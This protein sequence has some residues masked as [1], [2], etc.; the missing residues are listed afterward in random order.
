MSENKRFYW[1]KLKD[2]FFGQRAIKK[3]RKIAGGD[4][5]T[6]I[7]LKLQLLSLKKEGILYFEGVED[8]FVEEMALAIDEDEENVRFTIMFLQKYGLIEE[9][10]NDE[11]LLPETAKNIGS[12]T[13]VAARVRKHREAKN[14]LPCNS[15]VTIGNT[16]KE[17]E[18]RDREKRKEIEKENKAAPFSGYT[19]NQELI[20]ALNDF[21]EMRKKIKA[22]MTDRA[23]EKLLKKLDGMASDDE[24]KIAIIDQ[25]T[26]NSWKGVFPLKSSFECNNGRNPQ[27]DMAQE[28]IEAI[29]NAE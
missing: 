22:P 20:A 1:L 24:T 13:S 17:I 14:V 11:F 28:A 18:K 7:Y 10:K 5:Y 25:S 26:M 15:V 23:I 9:I 27:V 16:E 29:M 6:V 3:L 12:E 2:D 19:K 21:V 8:S 4:T